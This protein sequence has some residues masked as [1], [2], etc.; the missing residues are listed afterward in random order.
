[1]N[2]RVVLAVKYMSKLTA[3]ASL[4]SSFTLFS[5]LVFAADET[6]SEGEFNGDAK[7]GFI[8]TKTDE[9][10]M[11]I[12]SGVTLKYEEQRWQHIKK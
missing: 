12:N 9:T 8:Y 1:M 2:R 6:V 11:S 3:I 10:S 7:V 5:S 4:V